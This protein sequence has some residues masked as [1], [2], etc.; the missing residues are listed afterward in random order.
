MKHVNTEGEC[1]LSICLVLHPI[2]S[3]QVK[4]FL[5]ARRNQPNTFPDWYVTDEN[6][7]YSS[8]F[9]TNTQEI[10]IPQKSLLCLL[11]KLCGDIE[12]RPSPTSTGLVTEVNDFCRTK[13]LELFHLNIHG[14]QGN[15]D[16]QIQKSTSF[17]LTEI[18]LGP[19][20][21]YADFDI[22]GFSFL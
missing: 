1:S 12:K 17:G 8:L 22:P 10:F 18:F 16:V 13:G 20:S 6:F 2:L 5:S 19:N 4:M 7:V 3:G 15:F 14:L 21:T 11:I 9:A